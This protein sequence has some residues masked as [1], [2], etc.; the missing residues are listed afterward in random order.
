MVARAEL[1]DVAV[2]L[3][4]KER[5]QEWLHHGHS[6]RGHSTAQQWLQ[7]ERSQEWLRHWGGFPI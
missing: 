5:S 4:L 2:Q 3:R 6:D 1:S 7:Q